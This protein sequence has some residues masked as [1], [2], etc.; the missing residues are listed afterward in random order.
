VVGARAILQE[1]L[2]MPP[3]ATGWK[4]LSLQILNYSYL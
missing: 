1:S 3:C 2:E 4:Q